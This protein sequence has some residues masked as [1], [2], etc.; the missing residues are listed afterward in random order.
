MAEE[1]QNQIRSADLL[2]FYKTSAKVIIFGIQNRAIG[3]D[4]KD[5]K[6][7]G[8]Y[9]NKHMTIFWSE[10]NSFNDADKIRMEKCIDNW[11]KKENNNEKEI[12]FTITKW[13][14]STAMKIHGPLH[15]LCLYCRHN[16]YPKMDIP[17]VQVI[18]RK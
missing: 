1:K 18:W 5:A 9:N 8:N 7:P 13:D 17:H 14:Q 10:H 2:K 4:L 3:I 15:D 6:L 12:R 16:F 11:I